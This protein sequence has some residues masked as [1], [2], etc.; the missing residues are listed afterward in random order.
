[1]LTR[2]TPDERRRITR[3][4]LV[5]AAAG[6]LATI[7]YD[8]SKS[9]LSQLDPSPYNP[10]EAIRI[11]GTLI[12]GPTAG[13]R[14]IFFAGGA[15][16]LL[17]GIAFAVAYGFLFGRDGNTTWRR[18]L[19]T[20]VGWGLF[21]ETFQLTLFPGWLDIRFYQEFAMISALGHVVYGAT[22]GALARSFLRLRAPVT[23]SGHPAR[24]RSR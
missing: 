15:F 7:A 3:T 22:L 23:L 9:V 1:V 21:L 13:S 10:F 6:F 17:N 20:G 14:L 18:A 11:F 8:V 4:I 12:V 16:H 2:S 5:A 19:A 24:N